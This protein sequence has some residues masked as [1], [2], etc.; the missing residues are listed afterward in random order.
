MPIF[1]TDILQHANPTLPIVDSNE[2]DGGLKQIGTFS[3]I[4]LSASFGSQLAKFKLGTRL[5][6]TASNTMYYLS[7]IDPTL[8]TSWTLFGAGGGTASGPQGPQGIAGTQGPQGPQGTDGTFPT[9]VPMEIVYGDPS[10]GVG[11]DSNLS[12]DQNYNS[13]C[14]AGSKN[15]VGFAPDSVIVG[16]NKNDI[17]NSCSS[18]IIGSYMSYINSNYAKGQFIGGGS[19]N[20]I[21]QG[22]NN[23]I[24]SGGNNHIYNMAYSSTIIGGYSN[25]INKTPD[26]LIPTPTRYSNISGGFNNQIWNYTNYS[27]IIGGISNCISEY[28]YSSTIIGGSTNQVSHSAQGIVSGSNNNMCYG[29]NSVILGGQNNVFGCGTIYNSTIL[30]SKNSCFS[31]GCSNLILGGDT[32]QINLSNCNEIIGG[33]S[34]IIAN[35][36][37]F[38]SIIGGQRS[39]IDRSE[40]SIMGSVNSKITSNSNQSAIIG[41]CGNDL[42][43]YSYNSVI[44]GGYN[45]YVYH[46]SNSGVIGGYYNRMF[47]S[48]CSVIIG[49]SNLL[50]NS[51]PNS[52]FVPH[53]KIADAANPD[54]FILWADTIGNIGITANTGGGGS[55]G[56]QG[57]IGPQGFLGPQ[58]FQGTGVQGPTGPQGI[59]GLTGPQ[60]VQGS[61]V[62]GPTGPQGVQGATGINGQSYYSDTLWINNSIGTVG[63]TPSASAFTSVSAFS[64]TFSAGTLISQYQTVLGYPNTTVIH[65]GTWTFN[66]V[67]SSIGPTGGGF[68]T[69]YYY[70][71]VF[72]QP[73]SGGVIQFFETPLVFQNTP[74]TQSYS[75]TYSQGNSFTMS[76]SDRLLFTLRMGNNNMFF[77][78]TATVYFEGQYPYYITTPLNV[79]YLGRAGTPGVA[80]STGSQGPVGSQGFQGTQGFQGATGPAGGPQGP[81]GPQGTQGFQGT[82]GTQGTQ[83]LRGATGSQGPQGFQGTQGFQGAVGVGSTASGATGP[84]G[85]Q[86]TQGVQ[87]IMG[88]SASLTGL[89]GVLAIGNTSSRFIQLNDSSSGANMQFVPAVITYTTGTVSQALKFSTNT[90]PNNLI[91]P[92]DV[93]GTLA[94]VQ[95]IIT[96]ATYSTGST[97]SIISLNSMQTNY[98]SASASAYTAFLPSTTTAYS[99]FNKTGQIINIVK[100][101]I[102]SKT[103]TIKG[104]G[105]A[106]INGQTQ[107]VLSNPYQAVSLQAFGNNWY[108][109][110]QATVNLD[111]V[112]AVGNTTSNYIQMNDGSGNSLLY[113]PGQLVYEYGTHTQILQFDPLTINSALNI[114]PDLSGTLARVED[115]SITQGNAAGVASYSVFV[116][117][118][119][120]TVIVDCSLHVVQ[121]YLPPTSVAF[122]NLNACGQIYRFKKIDNSSN[123]AFI[124]PSSGETIDGLTSYVLTQQYQTVTL[125]AYGTTWY[126]IADPLLSISSTSVYGAFATASNADYTITTPNGL[127]LELPTITANRTLTLP[128]GVVGA[129]L[130]ITNLNMSGS[131]SWGISGGVIKDASNNTISTLVNNLTYIIRYNP[132]SGGTW[133]R[134][135]PN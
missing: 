95:D 107:Y 86:G 113:L 41:G 44:N 32:N 106:L 18:A 98:I 122:N 12:F 43:Y 60:G 77:G 69:I 34:N 79:G 108:A 48:D 81:T 28:S 36:S 78:A 91:L 40:G 33:F 59:I 131:F 53:L 74:A 119:Q 93:S 6:V 102:T 4:G 1:Y 121:N 109:L 24:I 9:L 118:Q 51:E 23:G 82:Q 10:G 96:V 45:N 112:L 3:N 120:Q 62:Q 11:Q 37:M 30:T 63:L 68:N 124:I 27:N 21:I 117:G 49:G 126:T 26:L 38:S 66:W 128:S 94:R 101:D 57:P 115:V 103:V 61:G 42:E 46:S 25:F 90:I 55:Q 73:T 7:S 39:S 99:S 116:Q 35:N 67:A 89:D 50:L 123:N 58:G 132:T 111:Q 129:N 29:Q 75:A 110:D 134:I 5:Y 8:T 19:N 47:N 65:P 22:G 71:D 15:S 14:L 52:V 92:A 97:G 72:K 104:V 114:P 64:P 20:T 125:Q 127:T 100:N 133:R 105:G 70:V 31:S 17:E 13:A 130:T 16:G 83:G 87:G 54:G 84:Q 85:P 2:L 80:G 88:S 56:P 135:S 76:A